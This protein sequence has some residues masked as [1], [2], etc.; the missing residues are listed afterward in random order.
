MSIRETRLTRDMSEL[1]RLTKLSQGRFAVTAIAR[2]RVCMRICCRSAVLGDN[3]VEIGEH[4]HNID[5]LIPP[6]WP[7]QPPI[8][9]VREPEL[10]HPNV[11]PLRGDGF[12][13]L[14]VLAAGYVCYASRW[15]PQH[16]L[17]MLVSAI[18]DLIAMRNGRFSL[19]LTDCLNPEAVQFA[20]ENAATGIFP[21]DRRPL[22]QR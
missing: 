19:T 18:Y 17:S 15:T 13:L 20:N 21:I 12:S 16:T 7:R 11:A 6:E 1:D 4:V 10:F 5:C 14:G 9:L 8:V 22:V 3:G 2:D